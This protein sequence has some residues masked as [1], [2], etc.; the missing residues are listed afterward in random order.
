MSITETVRRLRAQILRLVRHRRRRRPRERRVRTFYSVHQRRPVTRVSSRLPRDARRRA[1][2]RRSA[3]RRRQRHPRPHRRHRVLDRHR[4]A[5]RDHHRIIQSI[6]YRALGVHVHRR[7]EEH[8]IVRRRASRR[9]SK[10]R[11]RRSLSLVRPV[12]H[13][14]QHRVFH[15]RRFRHIRVRRRI[16]RDP[17]FSQR[18]R[19]PRR[20]AR[21]RRHRRLLPRA[22][23]SR[24]RRHRIRRIE[25][26][27]HP[28]TTTIDPAQRVV[29]AR[30]ERVLRHPARVEKR[31]HPDWCVVVIIVIISRVRRRRRARREREDDD[32]SDAQRPRDARARFKTHAFARARVCGRDRATVFE[33]LYWSDFP[34]KE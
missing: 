10:P 8:E 14:V 13:S 1:S 4:F 31:R 18:R 17:V 34:T 33:K 22:R 30:V 26:F 28:Q 23:E 20:R 19:V 15:R 27:P 9:Q 11:A 12:R 7:T 24:A 25:R 29:R 3:P 2:R 16:R 21:R 5:P 6:L 32:D